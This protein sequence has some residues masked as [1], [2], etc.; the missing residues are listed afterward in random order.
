[1][2]KSIY[3]PEE[4]KVYRDK[5]KKEYQERFHAHDCVHLRQIPAVRSEFLP[6]VRDR[7]EPDHIH[8]PVRQL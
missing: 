3:L 2:V 7:V 1:M 8:T 4:Y 6:D 5:T